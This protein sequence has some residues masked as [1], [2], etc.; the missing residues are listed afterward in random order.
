MSFNK[1]KEAELE[2]NYQGVLEFVDAKQF[3]KETPY[4][5]HQI[6][7]AIKRYCN[8]QEVEK[9]MN[10]TEMEKFIPEFVE[11]WLSENPEDHIDRLDLVNSLNNYIPFSIVWKA[12]SQSSNIINPKLM[13]KVGQMIIFKNALG[14]AIKVCN[15]HA[16]RNPKLDRKELSEG[17][18]MGFSSLL[19]MVAN[20]ALPEPPEALTRLVGAF[21][22]G[23][24]NVLKTADSLRL[25]E[26]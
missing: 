1:E 23:N 2:F 21:N 25:I 18:I 17:L 24:E 3:L 12:K 13:G 26:A 8:K 14:Q 6:N 4:T 5:S 11:F 7:G 10:F 19:P 20:N 16:K 15:S 9:P 22:A